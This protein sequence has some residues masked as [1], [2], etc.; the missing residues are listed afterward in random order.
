MTYKAEKRCCSVCDKNKLCHICG[1]QT[2]LACSDCRINLAATVYVCQRSSCRDEHE[3]VCG[4]WLRNALA[5]SVKLQSHYASLLNQYDGGRR[6]Q[7]SNGDAWIERLRA[8][9]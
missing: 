4:E 3:R 5:E 2:L 1:D 6:L 8:C 7:F 9:T